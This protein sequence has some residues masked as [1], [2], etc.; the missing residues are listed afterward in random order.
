MS[1]TIEQRENRKNELVVSVRQEN[2]FKETLE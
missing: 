2:C 1:E